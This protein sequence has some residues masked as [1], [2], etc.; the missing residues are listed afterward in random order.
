MLDVMIEAAMRVFKQKI[1]DFGE[2]HDL[3]ELTPE[4]ADVM[5]RALLDALA[6]AGQAGTTGASRHR[7][8]TLGTGEVR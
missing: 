7:P 5:G 8:L 4:L 3:S 1:V 2:N 6:Q